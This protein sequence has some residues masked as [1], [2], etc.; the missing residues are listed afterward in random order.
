MIVLV[1]RE[2]VGEVDECSV[3]GARAIHVPEHATLAELLK[4]VR[5]REYLPDVPGGRATWVCEGAR[6]LAI[7]AQEYRE[8]WPLPQTNRS[9]AELAGTLPRPHFFLRYLGRETPEDAFRRLGGD[10]VRLPREAWEPSAE[11]TWT[12]ALRQ[13]LT[14]RGRP[15]LR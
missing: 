4:V 15:R 5:A 12:S 7:V 8:P 1:H 3:P 9:L 13:L 6:P 10:P 14:P 2:G 11:I